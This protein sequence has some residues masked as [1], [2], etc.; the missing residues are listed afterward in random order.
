MWEEVHHVG[1]KKE[2]LLLEVFPIHVS[3]FAQ[4]FLF[5]PLWPRYLGSQLTS[6]LVKETRHKVNTKESVVCF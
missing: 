2:C 1:E 6:W 5:M 3:Y 4:F